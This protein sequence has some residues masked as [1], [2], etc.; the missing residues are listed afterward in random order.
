MNK[1]RSWVIDYEAYTSKLNKLIEATDKR[2]SLHQ[3]DS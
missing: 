2:V 3:I 1:P